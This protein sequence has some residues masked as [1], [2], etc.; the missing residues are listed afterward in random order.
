MTNLLPRGFSNLSMVDRGFEDFYNMIDSFFNDNADSRSMRYATFKVDISE[1]NDKYVV[2]AELPG[3]SKDEIEIRLDQDELTLTAEKKEEV[4]N[5]DSSKNY[6]HKERKT[7][8]MVRRMHFNNIDGE[9]L[10][11]NLNDGVLVIE[12]P[13]KTEVETSKKIEIQ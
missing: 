4:D 6:I 10:K 5:S 11:A 9:N 2:E 1:D 3:F 8:K 7:S 13:K 12:V